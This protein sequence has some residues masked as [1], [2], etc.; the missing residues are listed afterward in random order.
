MVGNGVL[1]GLLKYSEND[2]V[3]FN[4]DFSSSDKSGLL[5][6]GSPKNEKIK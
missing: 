2:G 4:P 3:L 1:E 6:I 5:E